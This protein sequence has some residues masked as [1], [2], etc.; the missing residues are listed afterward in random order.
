[1]ETP[2]V[3]KGYQSVIPSLNVTDGNAAIEFYV[4]AFG[5]HENFRM[6][7]PD[8]KV[9]HSEMEIGDCIVFLADEA[10]EWEALSPTTV[11]GCPFSLVTYTPDCDAMTARVVAAGATILKDPADY[12]WGERSALVRDPFGY[13]WAICTRTEDVPPD[14]LARRMQDWS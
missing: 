10:Q 14:E 6:S 9:L 11:G 3:P 8:G 12:P 13:R 2:P 4:Q 5:A 1:M 7:G